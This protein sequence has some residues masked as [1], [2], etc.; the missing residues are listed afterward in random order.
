MQY[1][2]DPTLL[3][4]G[5]VPLYHVV[6]QPI[7]P[8]VMSMQSSTDLTL[9]LESVESTKAVMLMK[10]STDPTLLLESVESTKVV[11]PMQYSVDPTLLLGSDV[12]TDYVFSI[13]R[14]V[15]SEQ[16]GILLTS[17]TPPP[18]PRMVSFDWNDLVESHLPSSAPFQIRVEF[19]SKNIYRCIVDEGASTSILFFS[20]WEALGSL[21]LV[22]ASH[23]LLSFDRRPS[24]YLGIIP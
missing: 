17:S 22:S 21:D 11:M 23:E 16:G 20:N 24:E 14:S 6:L 19:N 2:T 3:L 12:S 15:L 1:S 18:S 10:S 7:H 5:D 8:M 4:G 13:S 9:L